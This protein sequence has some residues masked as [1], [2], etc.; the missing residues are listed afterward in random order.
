MQKKLTT[1]LVASCLLSGTAL[2]DHDDCNDPVSAW[3][4]REQLRLMVE[5]KGWQVK[6]IKV[7]DGCYEVKGFDRKGNRLKATFSP[8]SLKLRELSIKFGD[9]GD[10]SDYLDLGTPPTPLTTQPT[11]SNKPQNKHKNKPKVTID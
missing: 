2:A 4:P 9:S 10:A 7:D 1:F 8:A 6:R 3:Q 11:E 5:N